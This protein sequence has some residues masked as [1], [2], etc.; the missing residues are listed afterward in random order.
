MAFAEYRGG[1]K[2]GRDIGNMAHIWDAEWDHSTTGTTVEYLAD[3]EHWPLIQQHLPPPR[4]VLEAG[5]GLGRWVRF[6]DR[7]G[8]EAHGVDFSAA[9][10]AGACRRWP[11]LRVL[12]GDLRCMPYQ[13]G[14]FDAIVSFGAIEHDA[15]G[16]AAILKE[17]HRVLAPG[18]ILYCT[19]PCMNGVRRAGL[20]RLQNWVVCSRAIRRLMGRAPEVAFFEYLFKPAEYGDLL[21]QA[22]FEVLNLVPLAPPGDWVGREGSVR[23]RAVRRL[24]RRWPW[25]MPHMMAAIC[26]KP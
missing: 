1:G 18:G 5:C 8:Y 13:G 9:G 20:M 2:I 16:P 24:H 10:I 6:L 22:G 7:H 12:V 21:K 19:V 4:R 23:G 14:F 15:D 17:L 25:L 26:R 11:G 3:S